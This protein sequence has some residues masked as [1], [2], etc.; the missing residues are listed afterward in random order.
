MSAA[1][2]LVYERLAQVLRHLLLGVELIQPINRIVHSIWRQA[3]VARLRC[4]HRSDA[5]APG[6]SAP[7]SICS[8]MSLILITHFGSCDMA[9]AAVLVA[10]WGPGYRGGLQRPQKSERFALQLNLT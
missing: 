6:L 7:F 9:A 10:V 4:W 8:D 5:A 2:H 1:A 3:R